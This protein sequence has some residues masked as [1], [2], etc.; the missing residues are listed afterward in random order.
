MTPEI[1]KLSLSK[2]MIENLILLRQAQNDI[3]SL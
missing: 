2:F 1:V 3:V